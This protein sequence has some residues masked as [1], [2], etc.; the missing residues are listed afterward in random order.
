MRKC[1]L[2][3]TISARLRFF[4]S[5]LRRVIYVACL[6]RS[7]SFLLAR[8]RFPYRALTLSQSPSLWIF[9]YLS[10]AW[11]YNL[12]LYLPTVFWGKRRRG[13]LDRLIDWFF[14]SAAILLAEPPLFYVLNI[15]FAFIFFISWIVV[16]SR[17]GQG[18]ETNLNGV[19][20]YSKSLE[21]LRYWN[22]QDSQP[23]KTLS[24]TR[25]F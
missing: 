17:S 25:L 22:D 19:F 24:P 4:E 10:C 1:S 3:R 14:S 12:I 21:Q 7:R 20:F 13:P 23:F 5:F 11:K 9:S 15:A 18:Y 16:D 2:Y 8:S 6:A